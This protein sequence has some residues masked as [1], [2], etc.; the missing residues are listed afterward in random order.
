L[1]AAIGYSKGVPTGGEPDMAPE[2]KSPTCR[3]D[4]IG[5]SHGRQAQF[6]QSFLEMGT[7]RFMI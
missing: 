6:F 3:Q 4:S 7:G 5:A 1:L 2:G